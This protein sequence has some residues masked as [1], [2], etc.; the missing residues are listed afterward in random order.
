M[1]RPSSGGDRSTRVT[2]ALLAVVA[3]VAAYTPLNAQSTVQIADTA[4]TRALFT[5]TFRDSTPPPVQQT[6]DATFCCDHKIFSVAAAEVVA[7]LVIPNYF[8]RHVADDTTAA[9]SYAAWDHNI[10]TGF[11]WDNNNFITNMFMHPFHGNV[12]FNAARSNGYNFWESSAFSMGGAFLWEIFG[13]NNR[14]AINDWV[15]TGFGGIAV[16]EALHRT[17][18]MIRDNR[19][20]GAG[21][22][23]RE[24]AAFLIDPVGGFNRAARGEMSKVGPNPTDRFPAEGGIQMTVGLRAVSTGRLTDT[25]E[26][27][28]YLDLVVRYGNPFKEYDKPFSSFEFAVQY[29]RKDKVPIGRMMIQGNLWGTPLKQTEKVDHLFSF[30]QIFDYIENTAFEF[31]GMAVGFTMNSRFGIS[32]NTNIMTRVQPTLNIMSGINS[33]YQE[34]TGRSYDFGSGVGLRFRGEFVNKGYTYASLG[35]GGVY[36][37]TLDGAKGNQVVHFVV[38]RLRYPLWRALGVGVDYWLNIRNSFYRDFPDVNR[39]I[40]ELRLNA[41]FTWQ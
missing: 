14:G 20:R 3:T 7:L 23:G 9:L 40:P 38:A 34:F 8:N 13:E 6:Q 11:E 10:R 37:H 33:E 36:S 17:A 41:A 18:T 2:S 19:A 5:S 39:V 12:Y 25:E 28:G 32:E 21:R 27:T 29:N 24:L 1:S 35:Y 15:A 31:G 30:N 26:A 16:G 4:R 22:T